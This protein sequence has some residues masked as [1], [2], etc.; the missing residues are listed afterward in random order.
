MVVFE[1]AAP[2]KS[3]YRR[4]TIRTAAGSSDDY[5]AMAEVLS[6]RYAQWQSQVGD[7]ASRSGYDASFATLPN[8]VVID[9]GKGQLGAG[10]GLLGG[11]REQGVA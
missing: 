5:A 4:F 7:L 2:K 11:F 6:R 8:L 3:D 1:G 10:L 9:G